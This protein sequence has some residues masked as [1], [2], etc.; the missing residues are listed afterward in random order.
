MPSAQRRPKRSNSALI[1]EPE[2]EPR[3]FLP[4]LGMDIGNDY[5]L[6]IVNEQALIL[7]PRTI[8]NSAWSDLT[9]LSGLDFVE[10]QASN[11]DVCTV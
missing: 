2:R 4:G 5:L 9:S 7:L 8:R 3:T 11:P 10:S 1:G 6:V